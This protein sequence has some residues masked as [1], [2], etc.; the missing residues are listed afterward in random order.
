MVDLF[1]TNEPRTGKNG[2]CACATLLVA[3][4]ADDD[5]VK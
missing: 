3:T 4:D 2:L 1:V 5:L